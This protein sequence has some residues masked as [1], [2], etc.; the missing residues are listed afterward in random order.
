MYNIAD[1]I[2][3]NIITILWSHK[4]PQITIILP[5]IG[6]YRNIVRLIFVFVFVFEFVFEF[7]FVFV[8]VF[9]Q[10]LLPNCGCIHTT[11]IFPTTLH[12]MFLSSDD[13]DDDDDDNYTSSPHWRLRKY[14]KADICQNHLLAHW[15]YCPCI[16]SALVG[17]I[18]VG[19]YLSVVE[20]IQVV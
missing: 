15:T 1:E 20:F 10:T 2:C 18:A 11:M 17:D 3:R 12:R 19:A 6:R 4:T 5:H 8:F 9:V 7:V 14:N 13:D 16:T